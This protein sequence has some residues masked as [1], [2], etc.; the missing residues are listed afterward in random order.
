MLKQKYDEKLSRA[1]DYIHEN[2]I[3][4]IIIVA[5]L[6]GIISTVMIY[7]EKQ[8]EEIQQT[9][10][11]EYQSV[12][13]V[14]F[15]MDKV[16]SLNPL[17]SKE[18]DTFYISQLVFSSLFRYDDTL[19]LEKDLVKNYSVDTAEGAVEITLRSD[20]VFSDGDSL[21]AYDV[22]FTIDQIHYLGN[23]YP[24][25]EYVS[26]I[27]YVQIDN[28]YG[29]TVHFKDP[30]DAALDN[31]VFP[32]VSSS[33]YT[34]DDIKPI[35]SGIYKYG[36]YSNYKVLK[37]TPYKGYYGTKAENKLQF[38]VISDKT[39]IPGLMTI[40]SL[41]A[42]VTTESSVAIEAEDKN[43]KVTPIASNEMEYLGFNFKNK[44][45]KNADVRKA[46]A[47]TI[48]LDGLIHDSYGGAGMVSDSIYFPGFLGTDNAGDPYEPDQ[49][50]ASELLKDCGYT[51]KDENGVLEDKDGREI[52]FTILVNADNES[53]VDAA[54]T[55]ASALDKIGLKTDVKAVSWK[56]YNAALKK[57]NFDMYL[58]G[59]RFD[60]KYNLKEMFAKSNHISYNNQDVLKYVNQ[61][62]TAVTTEKQTEIYGNLKSVL[63]DE[64]PYYCICYKTYNFLSVA[65]FEAD[66]IPTFHNRYDGC[67]SWRW[68]QV[69]TKEV[70]QP[71]EEE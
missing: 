28:D 57:K 52:T 19:N 14:Y 4:I 47:K 37:L 12:D 34:S 44:Y 65:R 27:D 3:A 61:M 24:Y 10:I 6:A 21:D 22:N 31:L 70:E 48:D 30:S 58:G 49:I 62:E 53:R 33:S 40:D 69:L 17:S 60:R 41:T 59:Y 71:E 63:T 29:L 32:I 39:K 43:L 42:G 66:D 67:G 36:S 1:F 46:I 55:I 25:Y 13:T 51:D 35:G 56:Q 50:G 54:R 2:I 64:L 18:E 45:L 20:A 5:V 23:K 9:E 38:K 15:A 16:K 7:H 68:E 11:T 8:S 26:K